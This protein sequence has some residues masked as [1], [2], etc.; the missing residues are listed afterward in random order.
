MVGWQIAGAAGGV[1]GF[2]LGAIAYLFIPDVCTP[3]TPPLFLDYDCF[4]AGAASRG[5]WGL[6]IGGAAALLVGGVTALTRK[7]S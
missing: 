1:A 2:G 3:A 6:Y 4:G 5:E 7:S